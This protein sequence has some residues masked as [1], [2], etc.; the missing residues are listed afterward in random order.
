MRVV[1]V[2][3]HS[4][5]PVP[6][7]AY[8]EFRVGFVVASSIGPDRGPRGRLDGMERTLTNLSS[9]WQAGERLSAARDIRMSAATLDDVVAWIVGDEWAD[10]GLLERLGV[11]QSGAVADPAVPRGWIRVYPAPR[12]PGPDLPNVGEG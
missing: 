7:R 6:P 10:A 11:Y 4:S 5:R 8:A 3:L 2:G 9:R 1:N 12:H